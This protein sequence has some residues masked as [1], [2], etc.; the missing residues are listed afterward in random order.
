MSSSKTKTKTKTGRAATGGKKPATVTPVLTDYD[1]HLLGE[2][3]HYRAWE[4]LGAHLAT[5][6]GTAGVHFAVWAPDAAEVSVIGDWNGWDETQHPLRARADSGIWEG[7]VPG[8]AQGALYKYAIVSRHGG[9]RVDKADPFAFA[10]EIR[11]QTASRVWDLGGY[12]WGDGDWMATRRARNGLDAPMSIYEVHLGS[13]MRVPE[14]GDRWLTYREIAP[15]LAEYVRETGF[16]H[17]ELLPVTEHPFDGSWGYQT[18]GY[19]APTS[20]F[21]TPQDFMYLVDTLH[22]NGIGVILDWVPGHFP[23]DEHGLGFFDGSHLYEH[24][25]P[26]QGVHHDWGTFVFNFGREG[27]RN[28]LLANALFWLEVYHVDGFRVD[29]VASML[30][31]DYSRKEGEWVPNRFGGRENLEAIDFLRQLNSVVYEHHPDVATV[32]EESTAWP[33]VS[34]PV[35]LGGLGFGFKWNMG[36]MHDVLAY[37][38]QDPL[39]RTYHH[40][41]MTFSLMYAFSEN[42][43]LPFSHDEVVHGKGSMLR[44]MPGDLEAKLANLRLLYGFMWAHPG[45]KL[46]FMGGEIGQHREWSHDRSVDWHLLEEEGHAGVKRWVSDLNRRLRDEP[47]LHELDFDPA[48]F[49]WIDCNDSRHSVLSL[50]RWAKGKKRPVVCAFN[51]T[52]VTRTN[53]RIGVPRAGTWEEVLNSDAA[54]Y[55]GRGRGNLGTVE[56]TPV[57]AHGK[58]QSINVTLPGLSALYFRCTG[59]G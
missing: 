4:K 5:E 30:Y 35:Y 25:D 40:H 13:W 52:P 24:A 42:F 51:F 21:G 44:K 9:Y 12:A 1:V 19:F 50:V 47:A 43:V 10:C 26:R 29:A 3:K 57:A 33:M 17:V 45:K 6:D 11:P 15:V 53:Y 54:T 56:T 14:Q 18:V 23:R 59:D 2:S 41:R 39:Y 46:L 32:A 36:W 49:E 55:G 16:T 7:F 28:F 58:Y 38:G 48:G 27:V 8:I 37:M 34:R 22:R 20:R 31:L